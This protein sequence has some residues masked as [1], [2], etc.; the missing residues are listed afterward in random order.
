M[1]AITILWLCASVLSL[2]LFGLTGEDDEAGAGPAGPADV[3]PHAATEPA[4]AARTTA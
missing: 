3:P 2:P 4:S 1:L